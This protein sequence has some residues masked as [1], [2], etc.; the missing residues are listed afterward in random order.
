VNHYDV[1]AYEHLNIKALA[2][3]MVAKSIGDVGWQR[4]L[5]MLSYKAAEAGRELVR[6]NSRGT[7]QRC[8]C[9]TVVPKTLKHRWHS[10][11]TCQLSVPRDQAAAMEILRLGLSRR[12]AT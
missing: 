12:E 10:C 3:S 5:T 9:G 8:I 6:V 2:R 7:S 1:I 11:P 4:F